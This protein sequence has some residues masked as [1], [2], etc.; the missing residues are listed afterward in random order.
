M[1][2]FRAVYSV[3]KAIADYLTQSYPQELKDA[4]LTCSFRSVASAEIA[5]E[6]T[7]NFDQLV[8]IFLHRVTRNEQLR[9]P[10]RIAG[11]PD[12]QPTLFLDLHYLL[13][14]WGSDAEAEQTILGWVMQQL[15]TN[16]VL[17]AAILSKNAGWDAD[18]TVHL[19][20]VNLSLEDILRIW[21]A[22][23]PKYRLSVG[24][25]ARFVRVDRTVVP[26]GPVVA[27]RFQIQPQTGTA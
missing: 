5:G 14:Y 4:G 27:T 7:T 25:L 23:G 3:G 20:P 12:L 26:A 19:I 6:D 1:A 11:R 16:P 9:S 18:D 24:Y 2:N 15:E 22:L 10:S 17:D 8:S 13:T 21:D